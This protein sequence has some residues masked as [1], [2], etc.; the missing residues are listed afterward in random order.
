MGRPRDA[1]CDLMDRGCELST[2]NSWPTRCKANAI[3]HLK[4]RGRV[5][6]GE[7]S[8]LLLEAQNCREGPEFG[9]GLGA[10]AFGK[11]L[12]VGTTFKT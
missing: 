8:L 12:Q 4:L 7:M 6:T 2:N 1:K 11:R 3:S 5:Y 9:G 10:V